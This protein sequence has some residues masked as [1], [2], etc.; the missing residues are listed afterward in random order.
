MFKRSLDPFLCKKSKGK[1]AKSWTREIQIGRLLFR[2]SYIVYNYS[3]SYRKKANDVLKKSGKYYIFSI[4]TKKNMRNFIQVIK[5]QMQQS[6]CNFKNDPNY[7]GTWK[8][9]L[10]LFI[11]KVKYNLLNRNVLHKLLWLAPKIKKPSLL[12]SEKKPGGIKL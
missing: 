11:P 7:D 2:S 12:N 10:K 3:Y 5:I 6:Y 4:N 9:L 1:C 8:S